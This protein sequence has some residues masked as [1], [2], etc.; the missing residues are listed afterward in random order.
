MGFRILLSMLF[1]SAAL[2]AEHGVEGRLAYARKGHAYIKDLGAG[3]SRPLGPGEWPRWSVDGRF[4]AA[5]NGDHFVVI[6]T[7]TAGRTRVP[8]PGGKAP[9]PAFFDVHPDG[10][11]LVAIDPKRGIVTVDIAT[12]ESAVLFSHKHVYTGELGISADGERLA[13]RGRPS[14]DGRD[15][16][17][18]FAIDSKAG[19]SRI[20]VSPACSAGLSPDGR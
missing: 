17:H 20:Y 1:V 8:G 13:A 14:Q 9:G 6:N 15:T 2:A 4:L 19:T 16:H 10:K 11:R 3:E 12:G 7:A 5:W 18:L